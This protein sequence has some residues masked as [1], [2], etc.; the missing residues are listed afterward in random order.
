M[1]ELPS[2]TVTFL[3]TDIEGSTRLLRELGDA[4]AD[5]VADHRRVL[6]DVVGRF[7]G[8][9]V[10]TQGDAFFFAFARASDAVAAASAWQV[11]AELAE[12]CADGVF[13]VSLAP[14]RE[15]ALVA[16]AIVQ[17]VGVSDLGDLHEA[18][19][20][21]VLDNFEHLLAAAGDLP[22]LLSGAP[23]LKLLVTSRV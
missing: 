15:R 17:A 6:R 1:R 7:Q 18:D 14:V 8:A 23:G 22:S 12:G 16:P 13:F 21:L 10:D 20:L 3:F 5:A 9:E 11:A 19:A 4:Y 2:G